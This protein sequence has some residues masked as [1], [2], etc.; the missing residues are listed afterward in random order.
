VTMVISFAAGSSIDV[1]GRIIAPRLSELLGQQVVV[2]NVTGAAGIIGNSRVA[3]SAPDGYQFVL[4]ATGGFAQNQSLYKNLPYNAATDFAPVALLAETPPVLVARK[5]LPADTLTQFIAYTKANQA[6]MQYGSS[7]AGTSTHLACVLLNAAIGVKV[8]HIPYRGGG[9][10]M[11]DLIAGRID[12]QCPLSAVTIPQIA[13]KVV[14]AIAILTKERS[15]ILADVATAHEQGLT[16]FDAGSWFAFFL[17]KGTPAPVVQKLNAATIATLET[18]PVQQRLFENG[19]TVV[20][21]ERR[22][23]QYLQK[24]VESEIAKWAAAIKAA[25]VQID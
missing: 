16:D 24:F 5:D 8:T 21:L 1:V 6:K 4:G 10:A 12:Y 20:A 9:P 23:P 25:G 22:S 19:A 3:K 15:K 7:G 17:P 18:P 2:E 11:Q 13:S 14:K